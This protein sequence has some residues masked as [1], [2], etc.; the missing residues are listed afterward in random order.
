M[1]QVYK[2]CLLA[3]YIDVRPYVCPSWYSDKG[4]G[5]NRVPCPG[6]DG[7]GRGGELRQCGSWVVG[8][9]VWVLEAVEGGTLVLGQ[10]DTV[11]DAQWQVGLESK[12]SRNSFHYAWADGKRLT[13][14]I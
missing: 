9:T 8:V 11:L 1:L 10:R 2:L 5:A 6:S 4:A 13:L 12:E 7:S 14:A 3:S